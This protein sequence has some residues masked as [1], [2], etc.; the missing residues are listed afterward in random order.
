L[1]RTSQVQS[2]IPRVKKILSESD[3]ALNTKEIAERLDVVDSTAHS[4]LTLMEAFEIVE[5]V[6]RGRYY[7]YL[8]GVYDDEQISK[9]LPP[10]KF[11]PKPKPKSRIRRHIPQERMRK[12]SPREE[13]LSHLS[14]Q[15]SSGEGLSALSI[16][17]FNEEHVVEESVLVDEIL[18]DMEKEIQVEE[19]IVK[20]P[21]T[22][23]PYG[24][25]EHLSK[26]FR[27]LT[28]SQTKYIKD[29]LS[30]LEGYEGIDMYN[31]FFAKFSA[32]QHG[33]YGNVLYC[34]TGRNSWDNIHQ[35]T[36]DPSISY[37]LLLPILEM[38]RW[39]SWTDFLTG[40]EK[41]RKKYSKSL[42]DKM[43]DDFME[44]GHRLVELTVENRGARYVKSILNTR[45]EERG[46][47]DQVEASHVQDWIYLEKVD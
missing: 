28:R 8:K 1:V 3:R 38:N 36:V 13:H 2:Q 33:K 31:T 25:V 7:F 21:I 39:A 19:K 11:K 37:S 20:T 44:S 40:L 29:K 30:W 10:K 24:T 16:I 12:T 41:T 32:L 46:L 23:K 43:L 34:S 15:A 45:I 22:V 6:M 27:C 4:L 14:V 18:R 35:V 26:G 5:K 47:G 42:Y 17:G 9:M